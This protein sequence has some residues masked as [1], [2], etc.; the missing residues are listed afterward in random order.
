MTF[1]S[2]SLPPDVLRIVQDKG[3]E[4][5]FSGEYD[6]LDAPGTYL[7]RQCGLGLF[8]AQSKFHSG[9]GWPSFDQNIENAVKRQ[10]DADGQRVEILC[11]RCD[12]HLGHVF[13]GEKMTVLNTRHCVN[14]LSLDF[15]HDLTVQDSSEVILAAGCFWGVEYW[16]KK[17]P[18]VLKVEVGYTGGQTK[19]PSYED[20]CRGNT[21]H[22]EA[23]RVVFNPKQVTLEKIMKFFFEI[24]DFSQ[25]NGQGPDIGEQ[26]LSVIFYY[27]AI[28]QAVAQK[29]IQI[30]EKKGEHVAT[31][32]FPI[33]PFWKAEDY[34]QAYY[35]KMR[36]IPY[37][38]QYVKIFGDNE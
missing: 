24:H 31:K 4:Y 8:R 22:F 35:D 11:A 29:L 34:H 17:L 2:A 18:G 20:V 21:G 9:C 5:P 27:D 3:T 28:Q 33:S 19:N 6:Q 15:V 32:L 26:Y 38:H 13:M 16:F 14:S 23:V 7:C 25:T 30:L 10:T 37:C 1:K 12:A 36:K